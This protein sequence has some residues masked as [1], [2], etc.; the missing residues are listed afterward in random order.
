[1]IEIR[2]VEVH[3]SVVLELGK[4]CVLVR[5]LDKDTGELVK[6]YGYGP[7]KTEEAAEQAIAKIKRTVESDDFA[8][9][10]EEVVAKTIN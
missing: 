4:L 6:Y 9:Q 3:G 2:N 5:F 8:D 7:Y 1:M 10:Y